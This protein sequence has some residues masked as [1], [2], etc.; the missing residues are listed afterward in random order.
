MGREGGKEGREENPKVFI[1]FDFVILD[2]FFLGHRQTTQCVRELLLILS[3][4]LALLLDYNLLPRGH[5]VRQIMFV[6]IKRSEKKN[7]KG[8]YLV[9]QSPFP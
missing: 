7:I 2:L 3:L 8:D 9:R 6:S 1:Y 5:S 4:L